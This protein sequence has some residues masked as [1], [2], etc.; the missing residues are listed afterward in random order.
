MARPRATA[1]PRGRVEE[2]P[3]RCPSG[4]ASGGGEGGGPAR[5]DESGTGYRVA[6][7]LFRQR[8]RATVAAPAAGRFAHALRPA[9]GATARDPSFAGA[10]AKTSAR[11]ASGRQPSQRT[12]RFKKQGS[13]LEGGPAPKER[14]RSAGWLRSRVKQPNFER[15]TRRQ[16]EGFMTFP[17]NF[18]PSCEFLEKVHIPTG[19]KPPAVPVNGNARRDGLARRASPFSFV[20]RH[21]ASLFALELRAAA[22][23]R[24]TRA[25]LGDRAFESLDESSKL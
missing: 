15:G 17:S 18:P 7:G 20:T 8:S 5:P 16:G 24:R 10:S 23:R 12:R 2:G 9:S 3:D 14:M 1:P 6:P 25:S 4:L 11:S 21:I 22:L 13:L 19:K